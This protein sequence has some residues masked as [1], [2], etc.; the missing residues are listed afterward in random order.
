MS[1]IA[2]HP[3]V[4]VQSRSEQQ[5]F[6]S[7]HLYFPQSFDSVRA[8]S[9][10]RILELLPQPA[11]ILDQAPDREHNFGTNTR[12]IEAFEPKEAIQQLGLRADAFENSD[13]SNDFIRGCFPFSGK[14]NQLFFQLR[15]LER[16]GLYKVTRLL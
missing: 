3:V 9:G 11:G 6:C 16:S 7:F 13:H 14:P 5:R 15:I 2:N 10:V 8:H 1:G 12:V 4:R